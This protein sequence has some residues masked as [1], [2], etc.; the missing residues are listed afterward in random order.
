[1][2]WYGRD[3]WEDEK[4]WFVASMGKKSDG[5]DQAWKP[6]DQLRIISVF[7]GKKE[8]AYDAD[9]VN[10]FQAAPTRVLSD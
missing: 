4:G 1:M 3:N 8:A 6:A 9:K 10:Y 7:L 5:Y 2:N